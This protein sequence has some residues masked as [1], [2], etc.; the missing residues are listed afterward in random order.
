MVHHSTLG[1]SEA[2]R[3]AFFE[4]LFP[5]A[6]PILG[7]ALTRRNIQHRILAVSREDLS[8]VRDF[9]PHVIIP[10]M[11]R[12]NDEV[13][14]AAGSQVLMIQQYGVGLEGVDFAATRR[15]GLPV[16]N[17]PSDPAYGNAAA[18]AEVAMMHLLMLV[19]QYQPARKSFLARKNWGDPC[20]TSLTNKK[21]VVLGPLGA[22]G[23]AIVGRLL[24]FGVK[25]IG[26]GRRPLSECSEEWDAL[27]GG[28][29]SHVYVDGTGMREAL[30]GAFACVVAAVLSEDTKGALDRDALFSMQKGSYLVNIARGG[31]V[32]KPALL[33]ALKSGHL[34]GAGLDVYHVEP[35]PENDDLL[36]YLDVITTTPH[37]AGV[38]FESAE[39][40]AESV[41]DNMENLIHGRPLQNTV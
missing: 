27:V 11:R 33:E 5:S 4:G 1:T 41:C 21:V 6:W 29:K 19:R 20:T 17:V 25:L 7:A 23:R 36:D 2:I 30:R 18:V 9:K 8:E 24:P 13:L 34:A 12:V 35:F 39:A 14:D 38:T 40:I 26:V 22:C 15:R 37:T 28:S 32:D 31:V 10:T 16:A 3:I